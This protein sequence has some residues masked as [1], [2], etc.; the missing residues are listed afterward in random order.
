MIST[1]KFLAES[2]EM[3]GGN[4]RNIALTSAFLAAGDGGLLTMAHVIRATRRE[5][6]KMGTV[7]SGA[8]FGQ[9]ARMAGLE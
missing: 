8:E 5:C 4:I 7:F 1:S 3:T 2:F 6:Q 9:Y